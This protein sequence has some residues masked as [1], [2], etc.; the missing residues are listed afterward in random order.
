MIPPNSSA[1]SAMDKPNGLL[2]RSRSKKISAFSAMLVQWLRYDAHVTDAGLLHR[3][4]HRSE[5]AERH[6]FVGAQE[7]GLSLRIT[8]LLPQLIADL[9]DVDRIIAQEDPLLPV[10][11]DDHAIFRDLLHGFRLGYGD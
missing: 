6:V 11:A 5:G 2:Q 1:C 8:H 10:D 4:H 7:N 9:V 3:I